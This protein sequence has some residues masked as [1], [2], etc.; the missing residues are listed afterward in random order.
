MATP[1]RVAISLAL[2]LAGACAA[3]AQEA[4]VEPA[5]PARLDGSA[6]ADHMRAAL[7]D[8]RHFIAQSELYQGCLL[9]EV[10]AA[11]AQ[12]VAS[13]QPFEPMFETSAR[14]KIEASRE[15]QDRVGSAVNGA[16]TASKRPPN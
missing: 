5:M 16:V 8:A 3:L 14:L 10:D 1:A 11:K 9:R 7:A 4:C 13:G 2:W 15:A 12:A 6:S